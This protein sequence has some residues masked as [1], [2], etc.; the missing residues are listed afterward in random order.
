MPNLA[1]PTGVSLDSTTAVA[2]DIFSGK[3]A[4]NGE[5]E[6]I[7]GTYSFPSTT[8][9]ASDILKG[10]TAINSSGSVITGTYSLPS[11]NVTAGN[12]L[13]GTS[14]INSSGSVVN[15]SMVNRGSVSATL[16]PGGSKSYS[17]GYY[18]GGTVTCNSAT[19]AIKTTTLTISGSWGNNTATGSVPGTIVGIKSMWRNG[20]TNPA[21]SISTSGSTLSVEWNSYNGTLSMSFSVAYI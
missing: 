1:M 6:R 12:M 7:T 3:T 16:N 17:A 4:Y 19:S 14:A 9:S 18:S 21:L 10:K 8:A 13:S 5:G 2:S 20:D 11:V 15:G